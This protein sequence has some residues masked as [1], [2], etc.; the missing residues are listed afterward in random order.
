MKLTT[1]LLPALAMTAQAL[2]VPAS[3]KPIFDVNDILAFVA[4]IFPFDVTLEAAQK[5]SLAAEEALALAQGFRTTRQELDDGRCGDLLVIF[6]R[7][8]QEPG[9]VGALVGPP[10]FKALERALGGSHSL[11]VQGVEYEANV[12]GYLEGGDAE[13][14]QGM[15]SLVTEAFS[16]CP[17]SKIVLSGYSQGGQLVHNAAKLLPADTMKAVSSVVIFGDP[18]SS[19]SVENVDSD[20]VLVIC[21]KGDDICQFGDLVKLEHL[22]Y[23]Q[24]ADTAADF[25]VS[26]AV[27]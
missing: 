7:G 1:V 9:N 8:T 19:Q 23:A 26:K 17:N 25:V 3:L 14:S 12:G 21:H 5:L 2:T 22:T 24:D 16:T 18:D 6:A 27:F 20:K 10:F 13:G 4:R 11:S 15:A